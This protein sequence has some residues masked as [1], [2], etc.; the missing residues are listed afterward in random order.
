[1][2][3]NLNGNDT[4]QILSNLEV[5]GDGLCVFNRKVG[6]GRHPA[7]GVDD[8]QLQVGGDADVAGSITAAGDVTVGD[9]IIINPDNV[10][11]SDDR[12]RLQIG[13]NAGT[14]RELALLYT[15]DSAYQGPALK[16]QHRNSTNNNAKFLQC[17]KGTNTVAEIGLNGGA[18]F[19][20]IGANNSDKGKSQF[21]SV[22]R[23]QIDG[24]V[25]AG[26]EST[27]QFIQ[28]N[29]NGSQKFAVAKNG[30]ITAP[31]VTFSLDPNDPTKVLDVKESIRTVQSALYRLKA[32]VLIPDTTVDQLR[33]R[34]LEALENITDD[35][36]DT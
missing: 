36:E 14:A 33:L 20:V 23:L 31:N 12:T 29:N 21:T 28:C 25:S 24:T 26:G 4:S 5:S 16:I 9:K 32:A 35:G 30:E 11:A 27:S 2:S 34:I 18:T 15:I 10:N 17:V 7:T 3:I 13:E 19:G 1:M 6:V 22:G 8:A